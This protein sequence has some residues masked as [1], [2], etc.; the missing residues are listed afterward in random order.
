[1]LGKTIDIFSRKSRSEKEMLAIRRNEERLRNTAG[2]DFDDPKRLTR[3]DHPSTSH[4]A[5]RKVSLKL[6]QRR[7]EVL[8]VLRSHNGYTAS[9]LGRE[10]YFMYP[11]RG[12]KLAANTP[13]L[14]L[15]ELETLGLV[16]RG[17]PRTCTDTG[18]SAATWWITKG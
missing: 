3:R 7:S 15:K 17:K 8:E 13:S 6:T 2:P 12:M 18:Q 1:M 14:R 5:G 9:E 10:F 4:S 16:E 11:D